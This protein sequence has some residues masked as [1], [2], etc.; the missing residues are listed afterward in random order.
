MPCLF[1]EKWISG[2]HFPHFSMFGEHKENESKKTQFWS[3]EKKK[4]YERKVFSFPYSKENTF[5]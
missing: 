1:P 3:K 2:N 4:L 5:P